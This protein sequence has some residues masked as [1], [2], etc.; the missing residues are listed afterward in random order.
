MLETI[1]LLSGDVYHAAGGPPWDALPIVSLP[2][3]LT[4]SD[5]GIAG[6]RLVRSGN[7]GLVFLGGF[8]VIRGWKF[9]GSFT[10]AG[11]G[12]NQFYLAGLNVGEQFGTP[13][14]MSAAESSGVLS[15]GT[16]VIDDEF[17]AT[18]FPLTGFPVGVWSDLEW[19]GFVLSM[20]GITGSGT[21]DVTIPD[22]YLT[23]AEVYVSD[24]P[25]VQFLEPVGG[26][27]GPL[28]P[29]D[30]FTVRIRAYYSADDERVVGANF[31]LS[32]SEL[33]GNVAIAAPSERT[34][35]ANGEIEWTVTVYEEAASITGSMRITPH[36]YANEG[37]PARYIPRA[38]LPIYTFQ[39]S[40]TSALPFTVVIEAGETPVEG[41][42]WDGVVNA[43]E[44]CG[45]GGGG[46]N[47]VE[48][49][50][51]FNNGYGYESSVWVGGEPG[52]CGATP[53]F[54][55]GSW[56]LLRVFVDNSDSPLPECGEL[57][58]AGMPI[59]EIS[60]PTYAEYNG[61]GVW[62]WNVGEALSVEDVVNGDRVIIEVYH[63]SVGISYYWVTH[64]HVSA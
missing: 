50:G 36:P 2:Q 15:P 53:D 38:D 9:E 49:T 45:T 4:W 64:F 27:V 8:K 41:C 59:V 25:D 48:I 5:S 24:L 19:S 46:E 55:D 43:V 12:A 1:N 18:S 3:N 40:I 14:V 17:P 63:D 39:E 7:N 60:E 6:A 30:T 61:G 28:A 37:V 58:L 42:F 23:T 21:K 52:W 20:W 22:G 47:V 13:G 35:D 34:T 26:V 44:D 51:V 57:D 10:S 16:N 54:Y 56:Q 31:S 32:A 11:V 29:G 33:A 62:F